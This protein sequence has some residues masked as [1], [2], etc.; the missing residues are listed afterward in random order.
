MRCEF[1]IYDQN[2]FLC[3]NVCVCKEKSCDNHHVS[4][5]NLRHEY[6]LNSNRVPI[7]YPKSALV[8]AS[9]LSSRKEAYND[10]H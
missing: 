4:S 2:F 5:Q 3:F 9:S 8:E 1:S 7:I 6:N 10:I